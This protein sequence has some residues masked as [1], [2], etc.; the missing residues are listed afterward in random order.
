MKSNAFIFTQSFNDTDS[1]SLIT[2]LADSGFTGINLAVN[3]HAS[4]DF[5]PMRNGELIYPIDGFHYYLPENKNYPAESL[6]PDK[7]SHL[8]NNNLLDSIIQARDNFEINA[9]AVFLHNSSFFKTNPECYIQNVYGTRF[10]SELCPS[11]PKVKLYVE[12]L[13]TDLASR[14]FKSISVESLQFHGFDHG[15][16]HERLF[17]Q[18]SQVTKFLLSLCFCPFCTKNFAGAEALKKS[19]KTALKPFFE[20][21]DPWI[22]KNLSKQVLQEIL[23]QEILN[24]LLVR[25]KTLSDLY[26]T[27]YQIGKKFGVKIYYEDQ[28][29]LINYQNHEVLNDSWQIG[30][31]NQKL[32]SSCDAYLPLMY[33]KDLGDFQKLVAHY[34]TEIKT[35]LRAIIRPT[36]PDC[37]SLENL[38]QKVEILDKAK[39][40]S[41]D[42]YLFDTW[43]EINL[44]WVTQ[45]LARIA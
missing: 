35:E 32:S 15:E 3:Y 27:V 4:R 5:S 9:W 22:G 34:R 45:A 10:Q 17:L 41:I 28:A 20:E 24:Y 39:V 13:V 29:P 30:I 37:D 25:E 14:G 23:G 19:I 2:K 6:I 11:N 1:K 8:Q 43:R 40:T 44:T 21:Q 7:E 31:D 33:R 16:H 26:K 12:G 38:F 36:F 18:M 42:F